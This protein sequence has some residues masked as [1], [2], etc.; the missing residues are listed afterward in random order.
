MHQAVGKGLS[1]FATV[2]FA[3]GACFVAMM[4]P[5]SREVSSSAFNAAR[6]FEAKM[7]M[8]D[9]T[10]EARLSGAQ[11]RRWRSLSCKITKRKDFRDKLAHWTVS[12][13]PGINVVQDYKRVKPALV[14]PFHSKTN[15][16]LYLGDEHNLKERPIY[17]KQIEEF[18]QLASELA[19]ALF[20]FA[21]TIVPP[22]PPS[23]S[24]ED[25]QG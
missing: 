25:Q 4:L 8:L 5:V 7:K 19:M 15:K 18:H 21:M 13:Y 12:L 3:I 22:K 17:L 9:A 23:E 1:T 14:P 6:S 2:E 10:A 24:S 11:L 20:E 16:E